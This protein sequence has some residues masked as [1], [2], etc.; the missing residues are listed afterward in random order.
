MIKTQLPGALAAAGRS[1]QVLEAGLRLVHEC[2]LPRYQDAN[3]T[4][5]PGKMVR[6]SF[7][8]PENPKSKARA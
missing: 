6:L 7:V 5:D 1:Q 2:Q 8:R 4:S 3:E